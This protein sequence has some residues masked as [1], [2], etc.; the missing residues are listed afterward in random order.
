MS[1][2]VNLDGLHYAQRT[3]PV[4]ITPNTTI[5]DVK[6][7]I[8]NLVRPDLYDLYLG[9]KKLAEGGL[10]ADLGVSVESTLYGRPALD[11]HPKVV[12]MFHRIMGKF[13][14]IY[15]LNKISTDPLIYCSGP[16][17]WM[18]DNWI[19]N[20][21]H[22]SGC[23]QYRVR[24]GEGGFP[25]FIYNYDGTPW[26]RMR[27]LE[28][29]G[30]KDIFFNTVPRGLKD[31]WKDSKIYKVVESGMTYKSKYNPPSDCIY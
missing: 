17:I 29:L 5:G 1:I 13:G 12:F 2:Y 31:V 28:C 16:I 3:I 20:K 21:I 23:I 30:S 26:V 8:K 6:Q 11:P 18:T 15:V 14:C 19:I 24:L 10:L 25:G 22:R 4:D 7:E 27:D 9:D